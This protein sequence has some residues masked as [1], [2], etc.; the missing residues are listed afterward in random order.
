MKLTAER[1]WAALP[2]IDKIIGEKRPLTIKGAYRIA[3]LFAKL[4]PE[5]RVL[6][7]RRNAMIAAYGFKAPPAEGGEPVL[8]VPA[9][10]EA[11]FHA[12]WAAT[13]KDEIEAD[14]AP[15][16]LSL[17]GPAD[18]DSPITAAEMLALGDLLIDDL[19]VEPPAELPKAA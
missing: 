1:V 10:K 19:E 7:H 4:E 3:R 13:V 11:E 16:P 15:I 17:L 6:E 9:D 5:F 8:T 2:V 12:N 18:A 14:V